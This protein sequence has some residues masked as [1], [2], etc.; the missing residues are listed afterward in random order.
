MMKSDIEIKDDIY[1]HIKG[2]N[3]GIVYYQSGGA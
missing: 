3:P 2:S 1:K